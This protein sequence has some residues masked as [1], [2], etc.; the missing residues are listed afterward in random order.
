MAYFVI[1]NKGIIHQADTREECEKYI[2]DNRGVNQVFD[3]LESE[4]GHARIMNDEEYQQKYS[5]FE[6]LDD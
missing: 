6:L 4:H 5:I 1:I 3:L 2:T